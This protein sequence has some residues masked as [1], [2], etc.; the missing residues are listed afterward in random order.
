MIKYKKVCFLMLLICLLQIRVVVNAKEDNGLLQYLE[1]VAQGGPIYEVILDGSGDFTSIREAVEQVESG[2]TLLIYPGVY[3]EY[4]EIID[5]TVNLI[6]AS[7]DNCILISDTTDYH[8]IPLTVGAGTIY[9]ITICGSNPTKEN[10]VPYIERD[11]DSMDSSSVYNWQSK[12]PGYAIHIDQDYSYGKELLIEGCRIIS[13]SNQCVGIGSRGR[14]TITF[15]DCQFFSNGGGCIFLH[16]TQSPYA[17]GEAY[18]TMKDCELR[19][20]WCPYVISVHSTGDLNPIYLTF[21]NVKVSTVAYETKLSYKSDNMNTW[22]SLDQLNNPE[23]KELLRADGYYTALD[24]ELIQY[25]NNETREELRIKRDRESLLENW[26]DFKEGIHYIRKTETKDNQLQ[27]LTLKGKPGERQVIDISNA[28]LD[29]PKDG[30]C[31]LHNIYLTQQSF[32]NTLIEMNFPRT[33]L[34]KEME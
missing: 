16:N 30:W 4:V 23:V 29:D 22:F 13:D 7:K 21:Q 1:A 17:N 14:N 27:S 6:G 25:C 19:N 2:A 26:P 34:S 32:G 3:E 20:Y 24:G 33:E 28:E 15:S 18:F 8:H 31:G 11:Y 10:I 12:F 5:K 9:N